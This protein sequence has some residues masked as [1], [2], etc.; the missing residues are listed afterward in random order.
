MGRRPAPRPGVAIY[1]DGTRY[2]GGFDEGQRAGQ[3]KMTLPDGTVIEG[4]W[5]GGC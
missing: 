3:G 4:T 2:E 1:A 5:V